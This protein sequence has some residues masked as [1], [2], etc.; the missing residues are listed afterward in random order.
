MGKDERVETW[1]P[2][3][4]ARANP[5]VERA[6]KERASKLEK[7]NRTTAASTALIAPR[8]EKVGTPLVNAAE[9]VVVAVMVVERVISVVP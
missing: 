8:L 5:V 6:A 7:E 2:V 9:K 3:K 1:K 4:V